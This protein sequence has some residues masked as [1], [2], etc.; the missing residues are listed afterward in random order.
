MKI[1]DGAQSYIDCVWDHELDKLR[2]LRA[3]YSPIGVNVRECYNFSNE[4]SDPTRIYDAK[5]SNQRIRKKWSMLADSVLRGKMD[6]LDRRQGIA[7][8]KL[9]WKCPEQQVL[10]VDVRNTWDRSVLAN[11]E[12]CPI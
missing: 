6:G 11:G 9:E 2:L 3:W 7:S 8:G 10:E 5:F 12:L 1:S 4:I